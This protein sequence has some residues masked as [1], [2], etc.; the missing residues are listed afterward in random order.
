[1]KRLLLCIACAL[2]LCACGNRQPEA[3]SCH[4]LPPLYPDYAGVTVP[5]NI[6]PL[7]FLLR[8]RPEAIDVLLESA[9]SELHLK[10]KGYKASFPPN[11]W[12]AFLHTARGGTVSVTVKA[13]LGK[14]WIRYAPFRWQVAADSIDP[15]LSYRL[16]EPGYEVWNAIRLVERHVESFDER[17]IADNNLAEGA[18]MN[19]HIYG[20]QDPAL[21]FFHVR[22]SR[23]GLMLNR[24]GRLRKLDLQA[25][26][27]HSPP[28]YGAFHP[29]GRY[30]VFSTN[31]ILPAF[32][33][34]RGE[35]MEVY[36]TA[37]DLIAVDWDTGTVTPFPRDS[38][39]E[40]PLRSFP[41][42]SA[43]GESVYYCEAPPSDLPASIRELRYSLLRTAFDTLAG[44]FGPAVDTLFSASRE[45]LSA[46]HPKASPDGR[47]LMFTVAT[48]GAFPIW[49]READLRIMDLRSGAVDTLPLVNAGESDSYHSWSSD[50][51]WFVFAS[52]RDDG[53]Y[54]KPYF[55]YIDS[56]GTAHK[57]FVLPQRDPAFYDYTLQSFNIPE[58]SRGRLPFAATDVARL[59]R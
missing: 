44:S 17:I 57:P 8:N 40:T 46:C 50:S 49:H 52:R 10:K 31:I 3:T 9:S 2:T 47:Y 43:A 38:A 6:A 30:G 37:S 24:G 11:K 14:R 1:M 18:C 12:H 56:A 53:L 42:F 26:G 21:S 59:L 5:C 16:I 36:D 25:G 51:R 32:H 41:V 7:N 28:V 23:G 22:G 19:C 34:R 15:Y 33:T 27:M 55:S 45:E 39:R 13:K 54:G 35:Q 48:Y 20:N 4:E 58:L 29:S